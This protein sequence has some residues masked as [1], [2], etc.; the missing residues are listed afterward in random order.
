MV[1]LEFPALAPYV[2]VKRAGKPLREENI[3]LDG[4][5]SPEVR[6]YIKLIHYR[7]EFKFDVWHRRYDMRIKIRDEEI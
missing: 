4:P 2:V 6:G 1:K 7:K 3:N 5:W